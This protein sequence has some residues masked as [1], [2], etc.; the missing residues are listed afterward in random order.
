MCVFCFFINTT[1]KTQ[2]LFEVAKLFGS[3]L[4]IKLHAL[5]KEIQEAWHEFD[6]N[7]STFMNK[8]RTSRVVGIPLPSTFGL[9][10]VGG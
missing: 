2:S 9:A 6:Q 8:L 7:T 3:F 1:T 5:S 4:A 10:K